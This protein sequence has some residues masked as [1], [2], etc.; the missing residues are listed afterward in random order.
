MTGVPSFKVSP[1]IQICTQRAGQYGLGTEG[2]RLAEVLVALTF[3]EGRQICLQD[4]HFLNFHL[5]TYYF[6][7]A[8]SSL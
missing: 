1:K 6:G 2:G 8:R 7:F 5:F 3:Q 4:R